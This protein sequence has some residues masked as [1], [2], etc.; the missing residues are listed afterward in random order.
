M[1][2]KY[3]FEVQFEYTVE[4]N[5]Y[6]EAVRLADKQLPDEDGKTTFV[7]NTMDYGFVP[8]QE[9]IKNMHEWG[10]YDDPNV[11]IVDFETGKVVDLWQLK[12]ISNEI[13][14]KKRDLYL[15]LHF[16]LMPTPQRLI[17]NWG[18]K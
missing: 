11:V 17:N 2:K 7:V 8:N 1:K 16:K 3:I 10:D 18:K 9:T 5:S 6:S 14:L 15:K 12:N 13:T 4:A